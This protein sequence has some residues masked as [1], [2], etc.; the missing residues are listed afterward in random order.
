MRRKERVFTREGRRILIILVI[1]TTFLCSSTKVYASTVS[2]GESD[3]VSTVPSPI[4]SQGEVYNKSLDRYSKPSSSNNKP[5]S[6]N[7]DDNA[8]SESSS[9]ILISHDNGK[10][11][12]INYQKFNGDVLDT[13]LFTIGGL[14]SLMMLLQ[15]T[16]FCVT[17]I[18]PVTNEI[19]SH[20]KCIGIDGYADGFVLPSIK[21]LL[22]GIFSFF[23]FSGY[24]KLTVGHVI[25]FFVNKFY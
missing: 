24:L 25:S 12:D 18:F 20:L 4:T 3:T 14:A 16:A 11:W 1:L 21:I 2:N 15:F 10:Y 13:I 5:G 9:P 19:F 22:L 23:C 8:S 6:N 17:R 7:V